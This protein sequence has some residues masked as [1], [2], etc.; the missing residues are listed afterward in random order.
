MGESI[1]STSV[2]THNRPIRS[3]CTQSPWK[4]RRSNQV[5]LATTSV[6]LASLSYA[7]TPSENLNKTMTEEQYWASFPACSGDLESRPIDINGFT[8]LIVQFNGKVNREFTNATPTQVAALSNLLDGLHQYKKGVNPP[9]P[10]T[11]DYYLGDLDLQGCRFFYS[12]AGGNQGRFLFFHTK[13]AGGS[14]HPE[15]IIRSKAHISFVWRMGKFYNPQNPDGQPNAVIPLMVQNHHQGTDNVHYSVARFMTE[16]HAVMLL[17]NAAHKSS[18][19]DIRGTC[20]PRPMSDVGQNYLSLFHQVTTLFADKYPQS[21]LLNLH[22]KSTPGF[23]ISNGRGS[24]IWERGKP[25]NDFAD[26]VLASDINDNL[27]PSQVDQRIRICKSGVPAAWWHKPD[28]NCNRGN[29]GAVY[30]HSGR[31]QY[32]R[33]AGAP[34]SGRFIYFEMPI[35]WTKSNTAK[36]NRMSQWLNEAV[37]NFQ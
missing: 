26:L 5:L 14:A 20:G 4:R 7:G 31:S 27:R 22:G 23:T 1:M 34:D 8:Q 11:M 13:L 15:K 17:N 16:S 29:M 28:G 21:V 30:V 33:T 24:S 6:L 12:S 32:G 2:L 3:D 9:S 36:V 35:T 25:A 19:P 10:V 37:R 18:I